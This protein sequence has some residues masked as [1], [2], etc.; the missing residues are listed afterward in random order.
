[1]EA[2]RPLELREPGYGIELHQPIRTQLVA[3]ASARL[4]AVLASARPE[5]RTHTS[6]DGDDETLRQCSAM[7]PERV[8]QLPLKCSFDRTLLH[9]VDQP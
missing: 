2:H 6:G 5:G 9:V 4:E 1:M 8:R 7:T 3:W